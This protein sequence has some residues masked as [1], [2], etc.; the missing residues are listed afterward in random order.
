MKTRLLTNP[1]FFIRMD[2][3]RREY[4]DSL[5]EKGIK[6][7]IE[8]AWREL[9]GMDALTPPLLAVEAP[10]SPSKAPLGTW[11]GGTSGEEPESVTEPPRGPNGDYGE[12][13]GSDGK[14]GAV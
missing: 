5:F 2:R 1:S 14:C 6:P 4:E 3:A 9:M 13:M 11:C 8:W 10:S 7:D 12:N